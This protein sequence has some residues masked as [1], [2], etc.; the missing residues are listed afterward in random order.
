ML[1][2]FLWSYIYLYPPLWLVFLSEWKWPFL[3]PTFLALT[4]LMLM[5]P[6]CAPR[7]WNDIL[8]FCCLLPDPPLGHHP[9]FPLLIPLSESPLLYP[10][11]FA[12]FIYIT[13]LCIF[14]QFLWNIL[15]VLFLIAPI[16][17]SSETLLFP[18]CYFYK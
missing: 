1:D 7:I 8:D 17:A 3:S 6:H 13:L 18:V 2:F 4:N 15:A 9:L 14:D 11:T 12:P 10:L 16:H 5:V